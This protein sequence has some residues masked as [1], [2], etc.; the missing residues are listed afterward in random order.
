[1]RKEITIILIAHRL[2]TVKECDTI[3]QLENGELKG[4][5]SFEKLITSAH[6]SFVLIESSDLLPVVSAAI[7]ERI[8]SKLDLK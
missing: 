3:F 2:T 1:M 5:G 4:Q 7:S 6:N 8:T